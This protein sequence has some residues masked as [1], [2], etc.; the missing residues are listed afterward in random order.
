[1][2]KSTEVG[3]KNCFPLTFTMLA[4][5]K[6]C[7]I[8]ITLVVPDN[9]GIDSSNFQGEALM[10]I[11]MLLLSVVSKVGVGLLLGYRKYLFCRNDG[12][13]NRVLKL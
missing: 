8:N 13:L 6:K 4:N 10:G 3:E 9:E 7:A 11:T 12:V 2:I 5:A 1:M